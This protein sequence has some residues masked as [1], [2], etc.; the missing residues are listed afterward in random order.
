MGG[1]YYTRAT[2]L[3]GLVEIAAERGAD[4]DALLREA[5]LNPAVLRSPET[6]IDYGGFCELLRR[7]AVAWDMPDIGLRMIRHQ[8]I[9]FLGPVALVTRMERTVRGA[10]RAIIANLVIHANATVVAFE[11]ADGDTASLILNQRDDAPKCRENTEL[12]MA[13]GKLVVDS[14]AGAPVPLVEAAFVHDKGRSSRA[15]EA[16]FACPIRYGAERNALTF[17]RALLDRRTEKSDVAYHA[18]IKKYL[19]TARA[20]LEGAGISEAVRAEIAR[21]MELGHCT[22]ESVADSLRMPPRSLQRRL[23]AERLCFRSLLDEWRRARALSLVTN[24]RLPLSEVS[25]AL[26]YSEQSV[27]TEAF[28]RWYGGTPHRFR[29]ERLAAGG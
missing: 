28:R 29:T 24:T 9:D 25:E 18:L 14:I 13:Q 12:V 17:D 5:G 22:L 3:A 27:F 15:V 1:R 16:H 10:L 20:E 2:K 6:A 23:Q 7:C 19:T 26:G 21:Q 8:Q 11:E 4:I